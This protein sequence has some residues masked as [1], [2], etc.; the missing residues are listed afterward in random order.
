VT[1]NSEGPSAKGPDS[2]SFIDHVKEAFVDA[3]LA[4]DDESGLQE[5]KA[6][7]GITDRGS[8]SW[9]AGKIAEAMAEIERR[10]KQA[11]LYIGDAEK[12]LNRL[13]WMWW[14]ALKEWA[15]SNLDYGKRSVRLLTTTLTFRDVA[16][17]LEIIDEDVLKKWAIVECPDAITTVEKV[18]MDPLKDFWKKTSAVPPGVKEVPA[19]EHFGLKG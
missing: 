9:A 2:D 17:K 7:F 14:E 6:R 12:R 13:E 1:A 4:K 3:A 18:L 19:G 5:A 10:K 16:A 11:A 8:A 15:R